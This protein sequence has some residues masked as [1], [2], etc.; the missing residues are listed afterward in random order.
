MFAASDVSVLNSSPAFHF[1]RKKTICQHLKGTQYEAYISLTRTRML[2]GISSLTQALISR[3]L[4]PYKI[5][6]AMK[7]APPAPDPLPPVPPGGSLSSDVNDWTDSE[8][9]QAKQMM[10]GYARWAVD[11]HGHFIKS[12]HCEL[13]TFNPDSIC[14]SCKDVAKDESFKRA[15]RK[16]SSTAQKLD[17]FQHLCLVDQALANY[18]MLRQS[19]YSSVRV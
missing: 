9:S 4:F 2:G 7:N 14:D 13:Q 17:T 11:P 5:F 8:W 16:V 18:S 15:V 3:R 10:S 12:T 19:I 1:R 6:P